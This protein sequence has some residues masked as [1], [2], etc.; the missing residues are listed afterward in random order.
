MTL[1][2]QRQTD[3]R[4]NLEVGLMMEPKAIDSAV[5]NYD[6]P[7]R[8]GQIKLFIV[9]CYFVLVVQNMHE[10]KKTSDPRP[11]LIFTRDCLSQA[12]SDAVTER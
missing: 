6:E 3:H 8:F 5:S 7:L 12:S 2:A 10:D 1:E 11:H 9:S 4:R